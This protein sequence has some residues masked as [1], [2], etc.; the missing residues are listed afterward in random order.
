VCTSAGLAPL[1]LPDRG[2]RPAETKGEDPRDEGNRVRL[3]DGGRGPARRGGRAGRDAEQ[4]RLSNKQAAE[5][6]GK[7]VALIATVRNDKGDRWSRERWEK[8]KRVFSAYVKRHKIAPT[9]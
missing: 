8:V 1:N 5:A 9:A 6:R 3:A 4:E 7:S 2:D